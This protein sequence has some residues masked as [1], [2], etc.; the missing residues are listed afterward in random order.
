[1]KHWAVALRCS[2]SACASA[3][4]R[5]RRR[6]RSS[7]VGWALGSSLGCCCLPACTTRRAA[8]GP[9]AGCTFN[10]QHRLCLRLQGE[11][12]R[13]RGWATGRQRSR[14]TKGR[15]RWRGVTL[16]CKTLWATATQAWVSGGGGGGARLRDCSRGAAASC[17]LV[18]PAPLRR[19]SRSVRL[20][21]SPPPA[22]LPQRTDVWLLACLLPP[23]CRRVAG[24]AAGL[25]GKL[26]GLPARGGLPPWAQH[27]AA[28]RRRRVCGQQ[29]RWANPFTLPA[30]G[31]RSAPLPRLWLG[32]ARGTLPHLHPPYFSHGHLPTRPVCAPAAL[33]LA[34]LGD[35]EG[36][37]HEMEGVARW[38]LLCCIL[39]VSACKGGSV[40]RGLRARG[41]AVPRAPGCR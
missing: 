3:A 4:R 16:T 25:P 33:M 17:G 21:P 29:R 34:Q 9:V 11:G 30:P 41:E 23:S 24:G 1:M 32:L 36:A 18:A 26:R 20:R 10:P 2:S 19:S 31:R 14:I 28:P 13:T 12:W 35:E 38:V 22:L 27:H 6:P 37:M 5:R 15:W 8:G 7:A 39:G 40:A